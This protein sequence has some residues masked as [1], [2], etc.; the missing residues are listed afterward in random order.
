M[1]RFQQAAWFG[2]VQF[3][4]VNL[5]LPMIGDTYLAPK[6]P[7]IWYPFGFLNS[8]QKQQQNRNK[9]KNWLLVLAS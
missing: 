2:S 4:T 6:Q 7:F 9:E 3:G 8:T 1:R 5:D